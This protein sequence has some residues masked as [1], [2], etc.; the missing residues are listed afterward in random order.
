M[1]IRIRALAARD[2]ADWLPLFKGY[3][4]FYKA[5]V[6]DDVIEAATTELNIRF[7]D[8]ETLISLKQIGHAPGT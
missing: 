1:T 8:R 7:D 3:I 5:T 6:A 2:K 4:A